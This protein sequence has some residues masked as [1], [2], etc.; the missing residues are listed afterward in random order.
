MQVNR[1]FFA[2]ASD[3]L[4]VRV[5]QFSPLRLVLTHFCHHNPLAIGMDPW[6]VHRRMQGCGFVGA[7]IGM[8]LEQGFMVHAWLRVWPRA[9]FR[10]PS[11]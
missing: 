11:A 2:T 7:C 5:W 10:W 1:D 4:T 8:G 6:W 3:D 9:T